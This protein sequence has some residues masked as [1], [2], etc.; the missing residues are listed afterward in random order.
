MPE[1]NWAV[2]TPLL[3]GA[4]HGAGGAMLVDYAAFRTFKRWNDLAS[5][6]WGVA[7]LRWVQ[8]ALG[9]ALVAAGITG[10]AALVQ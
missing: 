5:Y 7:T 1:L 9:G 3:H 8:G 2:I 10:G 6:D 4:L